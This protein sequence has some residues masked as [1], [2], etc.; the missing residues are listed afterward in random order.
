MNEQKPIKTAALIGL[1]AIGSFL[2]VHL[3]TTL[4]QNLRIIAGGSRKERLKRDGITVNGSNY[5]FNIV[6]PSDTCGQDYPE[7]AIIITK[8]TTLPQAVRDIKNQIGPDTIIMAPLNGVEAEEVVAGVYGWDNLI[9]SLA[10][11]SVVMKDGVASFDTAVARMEFGEKANT[12]PY[13]PRVRAVKELFES[14]GIHCV[15]PEDME[16]AI[17]YKYMC[18]VSENQCAAVL[19]IPFGA[20]RVSDNANFIREALMREVIAVARKKGIN[21]SKGD[22]EQQKKTLARVTARNKPSTLQD[23]EAGRKTE[24]EM[25]GGAMMRMGREL[26]VPTPYNEMFYYAIKTLEE[27][28]E[29]LF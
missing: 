3:Q 8:F 26:G 15:I 23:I 2:A 18:N 9:Y 24:V 12:E 13:T 19:G 28:N 1:G 21:L 25:F 11:V 10:K 7:L 6:D 20:W 4:G 14:S 17:W 5:H 16:R 27:K 29:H 22:M